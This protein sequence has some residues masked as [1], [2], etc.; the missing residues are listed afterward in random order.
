MSI[1]EAKKEIHAVFPDAQ[2]ARLFLTKQNLELEESHGFTPENTRFAEGGCSDEINEPEY[3]LMER[4]W[5]ER[6]K[7]GGLAGYCHGGK[8]SLAAVSHHIPE[9]EGR[10]NLLL[11]AGPHIGYHKGQWGRVIRPG[12]QSLSDSCG[13]LAAALRTGRDG[14]RNKTVDPLDRQQQTVEQMV[15]P[16]LD[17]LSDTVGPDILDATR[18]L[19]ERI[20]ADLM[21]IVVDL[22]RGFDGR[23][24]V[25]TG[26]IV[27]TAYGNFF[28]PHR[29]QVLSE[30]Y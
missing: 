20:D 2:P 3:K 17:G 5:G 1:E 21:T 15:L 23:T 25:I 12:Q 7:F 4:Y 16:Y 19:M 28:S 10:K 14:I 27:N 30:T 24:A 13:S 29:V 18:F 22:Q 8:S 11:L 6:F 26:I 9:G